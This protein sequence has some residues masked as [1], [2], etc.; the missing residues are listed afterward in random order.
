MKQCFKRTDTTLDL[1]QKAEK[2]MNYTVCFGLLL[3]PPTGYNLSPVAVRYKTKQDYWIT[4]YQ[5]TNNW[6]WRTTR[7]MAEKVG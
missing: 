7:D 1:S 5:D 3:L 4:E 6:Y 2:G